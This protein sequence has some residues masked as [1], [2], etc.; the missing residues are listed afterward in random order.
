M[1]MLWLRRLFF[2][3]AALVLAAALLGIIYQL[4]AVSRERT[5]YP[6]PGRLVDIGGYRLHIY[7]LGHGSPAVVL[8]SGAGGSFYDWRKV[9]PQIA[10]F[11]EA[12]LMIAPVLDTAITAHCRVG[13]KF[14]PRNSGNYLQVLR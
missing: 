2:S 1:T 9:Q 5:R 6:A 11:T 13:A 3:V 4:V 10:E 8:D 14:I 7:C 12:V